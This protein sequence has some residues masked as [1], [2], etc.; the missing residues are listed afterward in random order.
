LAA[1]RELLV[2]YSILLIYMIGPLRSINGALRALNEAGVVLARVQELGIRLEAAR[3]RS[4]RLGAPRQPVI[5]KHWHRLELNNVSHSYR[6]DPGAEEF[7]IGPIN[8]AFERGEIV[9]II[10]GNGSGKTTLAKLLTG[11]Y[12]PGSGDRRVDGRPVSPAD[13]EWYRRQFAAIFS[14]FFLFEDLIG[15]DDP[16]TEA[17]AN[18]LLIR[19]KIAHKVQIRDHALSTTALS[20]GERKRIALAIACLQDRP[21]YIFDEWGA[22]QD[23]AFKDVFYRE[24]LT[25]LRAGGKLVI[26]ISHDDRYFDLADKIVSLERGAPPVVRDMRSAARNDARSLQ[27]ATGGVP[28]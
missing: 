13:A 4:A 18:Q 8:L 25:E 16:S 6:G 1:D 21:V 20:L 14:D 23:P 5:G 10:G 11:L 9:F 7:T 22:E 12:V 26:A 24:I 19:L 28:G 27:S 17:R 3:S 2:G 15:T